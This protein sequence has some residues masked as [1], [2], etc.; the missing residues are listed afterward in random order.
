MSDME[1]LVVG[2]N[3]L[4]HIA[5]IKRYPDEDHKAPLDF[6]L[7]EGG[8]QGGTSSCCIANL[9]GKVTYVC[10]LGDDEAGGFCLQRLKDFGVDTAFIQMIEG[11]KTPEAYIF[12]TISNGKRTIIYESS[13]LPK[14]QI[15]DIISALACRPRVLLL[16]PEVTYLTGAIK[17][18][19]TDDIKIVYDCERWREGLHE[20]MAAADF[21]IPSAV[22]LE[23][24]TL[25]LKGGSFTEQLTQLK[26]MISGQL[27]VTRGESGAWYFSGNDLYHVPA[28]EIVVKDTTGA[29]DNFH[30]AF[31][32][33]VSR[34]SDIHES[35]R[36]SVAV[37]SLSCRGYGGRA[38][39]PTIGEARE[40]AATLA[41]KHRK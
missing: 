15:G 11:G 17:P 22:F 30:A 20:M 27:I 9:G 35:V 12:V 26:A 6:R 8:G 29:G 23:D 1:V 7:V 3:C 28:P 10:K 13:S 18:H 31:A 33:A 2:R 37:A 38:G 21:F 34:G 14:L 19:L 24:G 32:L 41:T 36:F 25:G 39:I 4:D 40:L 16:D 5:G